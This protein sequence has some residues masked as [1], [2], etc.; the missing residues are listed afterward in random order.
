MR[1]PIRLIPQATSLH[2][3]LVLALA[4]LVALVAAG[5]AYMLIER[6]RERRFLEL[7]GRAG[8]IAELFSRSVAYP[9][10]NVDRAA[11]DG[12][13]AA[14]APNP[15]VAEFSVT[16]V[17]YGT[18]SAVTKLREADLLDPI[19][20]VQAIEYAPPGGAKPQK[21]GEVRVVMTRG[22][23]EQA[24]AAA[25]RVIL[26]LV[27]AIVAVLYA[28]TFVL[29][30]R[31]VGAPIQ[32]LE[33]MVDR[34]AIGDLDARCAIES[35]DELGRLAVRVNTMA[36]RLRDSARRLRDSEATYR[37]IFENSLEGIFRLDRSGGLHDANPA[38][39]RLMGY[40]T[41]AELMAAVNGEGGNA[42]PTGRPP[43][44]TPAQI[45]AQFAALAR[46]GEIAGM[47]LQLTRADG[48]PIWVQ[49]NARWQGGVP[50]DGGGPA[51]FDGLI[52]DI[53]SRKQALEDLR[54]HRDHLEEAVRE[55]TAQLV[56]AMKRAEVANQAKS[57]FLA[58]MSHE[59]RT[60]M[61][62]I[63]GMSY[64]ALESGLNP[65]QHDY[66]QKV[67]R[68][69]ESLLGIINDILD[70]SK[71]EAGQ[72]DMEQIPFELGDVLD[73]LANLVGLKVEEKGLELVFVLPPG[74]P[75]ML[76]G[77][78]LRLGQV[79]LNLGNNAAKFTDRGEVVVAIEELEREAGSVLLRFEVR[80]TGVGIAADQLRRLFQP[81]SQADASTSR[82]FG[83][84]GL[85]LAIGRH[86]VQ[87]MGGDIGVESTP[88]QGSRFF[89][90][91]RFGMPP[92][93]RRV[94][95][96][97]AAGES[98]R[99]VRV[100]VADD[101][102]SARELL[103]TMSR[104]LG[105]QV[106]V[107]G[108]GEAAI[109]AVVEADARDEPFE[110]LLLDWKMP[111][112]DGI[113]CVRRLAQAVQRHRPPTV[114]M[115]TAFGR[116]EVLRQ[117][118]QQKLSVAAT[119]TKPVTPSTLLDT[120]LAALGRTRQHLSR[121]ALREAALTGKLA[122]LAGARVLVVE[123]NLFNQEVAR[124]LL[125]RVGIDVRVAG[126]G[127]EA[128]ELLS[129]ED[130]DGV[131]M[132][133]QMPVMDGYAATRALR[134]EPRWRDL[135]VIALTANAMVGDRE[136]AIAAGMNDHI[137]KPI[138]VQEMLAT[139]ARWVRPRA[140]AGGSPASPPA[141]G[142]AFRALPGIDSGAALAAVMNDDRLYRR[143]LG[144]FVEQEA[145]FV[146]RFRSACLAGDWG[147]AKH[148]THDLKGVAA[149]VGADA[150]SA[151]AAALEAACGRGAEANEIEA[152][153][154]AV[155]RALEPVITGV[156][157]LETGT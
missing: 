114:L 148:M 147:R 85:G 96:A 116:N 9:L 101:N 13:L 56:D 95:R 10:W 137:A 122:G 98:L 145:G 72:L 153:V 138:K 97:R 66:V 52:T 6:E 46:D 21:I 124:E 36:D 20:R 7:E 4:I 34:I 1:L 89:F 105:M 126:N 19:V 106:T 136:K 71:I 49:L 59:I 44:F 123:D 99:G 78:P 104:T 54:S 25:R 135:P 68:S 76:I 86:L 70:F 109:R 140:V 18:V 154:D 130:F 152:L 121:G 141:P 22:L 40:A 157:A 125:N 61:N 100:L 58:N 139:L 17:G 32:R 84:T 149:S 128:L 83:G 127:S 155:S 92:E 24:V 133:C 151:A 3:K 47:E 57:E 129:R 118:A 93:R 73:N 33:A 2:A 16:A 43:L 65:Q 26:A 146:P 144:M 39:A 37:G 35:G 67:H 120:C 103:L 81:F 45:E 79:L 107:T 15:E 12:Q 60:P 23:V 30:R 94:D 150:V 75:G 50:P 82:R 41:S 55:R 143:L 31:M 131:L 64:L 27:A 91:A 5:S 63:L 108:D 88:G 111:G 48:S 11:I 102:D 115:L 74:L 62:A 28:A 51:G 14:L 53:T 77:D 113:E 117:L 142:A 42:S 110:L 119:L 112:M 29:L 156:R 38:L 90:S 134:A 132:D 80:D 8:R 87:K 69:A